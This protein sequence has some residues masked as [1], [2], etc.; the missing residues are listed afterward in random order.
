MPYTPTPTHY[1]LQNSTNSGA[2]A[3]DA[4][5]RMAMQ[6]VPAALASQKCSNTR[7]TAASP[8][9]QKHT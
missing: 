7:E 1:Y 2:E 6:P 8:L 3:V 5:I 4:T 9:V